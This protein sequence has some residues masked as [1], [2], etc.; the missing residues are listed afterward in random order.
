M[1]VFNGTSTPGLPFLTE[2][3]RNSPIFPCLSISSSIGKVRGVPQGVRQAPYIL[4]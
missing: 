2:N 4:V 3:G 1:E